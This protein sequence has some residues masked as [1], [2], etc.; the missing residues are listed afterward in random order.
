VGNGGNADPLHNHAVLLRR[1]S[2]QYL[3]SD[4]NADRLRVSSAAFKQGGPDG[5]VSVHL[6]PLVDYD[7]VARGGREQYLVWLTVG[8]V[9]RAGLDVVF[10]PTD[11][12]P[13]HCDVVGRKTNAIARHLARAS[14][15]VR[16]YGPFDN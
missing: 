6:W 10:T 13:G 2:S 1:V 7:Q 16:G 15:W 14:R 5:D 3:V 8:D 12:E 4:D 11:D 9:R